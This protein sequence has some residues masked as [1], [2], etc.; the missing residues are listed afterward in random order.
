MK[1]DRPEATVDPRFHGDDG[2]SVIPAKA[3]I[4]SRIIPRWIPVFTGMTNV[5]LY[6]PVDTGHTTAPSVIPAKAGI[7]SGIILR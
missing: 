4:H 3:G 7:H 6:V 2:N 5:E 1:S